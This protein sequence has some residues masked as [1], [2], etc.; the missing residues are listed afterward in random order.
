MLE[1]TFMPGGRKLV[2]TDVDEYNIVC[3]ETIG[4]AENERSVK[5]W[6][7]PSSSPINSEAAKQYWYQKN[8]LIQPIG[9]LLVRN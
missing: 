7:L 2:L 6:I 4:L 3:D 8:H 9:K 1:V 5:K